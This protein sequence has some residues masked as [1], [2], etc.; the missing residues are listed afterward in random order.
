MGTPPQFLFGPPQNMTEEQEA[1]LAD[2][3]RKAAELNALGASVQLEDRRRLVA[4]APLMCSCP[5]W[6]DRGNRRPPQ[7]DCVIHGQ[8]LVGHSG[9]VL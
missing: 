1:Q 9:E 4:W 6:Y 5:A 8:I 2:M 7:V 3:Q